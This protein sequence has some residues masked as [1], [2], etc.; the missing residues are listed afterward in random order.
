MEYQA[1]QRG[2][3]RKPTDSRLNAS[4]THGYDQPPQH[5]G[6]H[7]TDLFSHVEETQRSVNYAESESNEDVD[8]VQAEVLSTYDGQQQIR[9]KDGYQIQDTTR[10]LTYLSFLEVSEHVSN[11]V[12]RH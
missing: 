12:S 2:K 6:S 10:D 7:V 5:S 3:T 4:T 9:L 8:N 11:L 1:S